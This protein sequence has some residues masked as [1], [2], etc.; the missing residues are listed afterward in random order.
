M[1]KTFIYKNRPGSVKT[2]TV[3]ELKRKLDKYPD[4]MPVLAT[5]DG[6]W[7]IINPDRFD[8]HQVHGYDSSIGKFDTAAIIIDV[9]TSSI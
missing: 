8:V 4:D 6:T 7:R 9:D 2:I 5:F 1:M 3:A